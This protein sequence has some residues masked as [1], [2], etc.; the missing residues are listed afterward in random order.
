[1]TEAL[2]LTAC[3]AVLGA[4]QGRSDVSVAETRRVVQ[5]AALC[6]AQGVAGPETRDLVANLEKATASRIAYLAVVADDWPY[7]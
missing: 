6:I 1:V 2:H 5:E 4:H 3:I 7:T